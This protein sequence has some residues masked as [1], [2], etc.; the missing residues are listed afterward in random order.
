MKIARNNLLNLNLLALLLLSVLFFTACDDDD[1]EPVNEEEL[2]TTLKMVFSP[3]AGGT[4]VTYQYKDIDGDG[5][6]APTITTGDLKANTAYDVAITVLNESETP[7]EDITEEI[8]EEDED[9]QFFFQAAAGLNLSFT[10]KDKDS[11]NFPVGLQTGAQAGAASTGSLT[12]T[13]RHEPNKSASGV[14]AGNIANAGGETDIEVNFN[15][16]IK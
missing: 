10:Y 5:P 14:S 13:L 4:S 11:G 9:H 15:V 3:M 2:I 6:Q 12:V 7:A 8:Q 1:P 16:A